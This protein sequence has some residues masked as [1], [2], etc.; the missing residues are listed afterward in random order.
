MIDKMDFLSQDDLPKNG[1][2][3]NSVWTQLSH[4][5]VLSGVRECLYSKHYM[6]LNVHSYEH[7]WLNQLVLTKIIP[8][9]QNQLLPTHNQPLCLKI[10]VADT[11]NFTMYVLR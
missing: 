4:P 7:V 10:T 8:S 9:G 11:R 2:L 1:N 5:P 6:V 3:E